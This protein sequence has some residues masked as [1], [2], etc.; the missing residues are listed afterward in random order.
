MATAQQHNTVGPN[1]A[2]IYDLS[3]LKDDPFKDGF[4]TATAAYISNLTNMVSNQV[5]NNLTLSKTEAD[6]LQKNA[7][8]AAKQANEIAAQ[9]D[10]AQGAQDNSNL[11][12]KVLGYLTGALMF[13]GGLISGDFA[14]MAMAVFTIT[15]QAS[16]GQQ[17]LENALPSNQALKGLCELAISFGEGVGFGGLGMALEKSITGIG[18]EAIAKTAETTVIKLGVTRFLSLF[19]QA[20]MMNNTWMDLLSATGMS[21]DAAT[22]LSIVIGLGSAI[23][24]SALAAK[25][26]EGVWLELSKAMLSEQGLQTFQKI[27]FGLKV[28]SNLMQVGKSAAQIAEAEYIKQVADILAKLAVMQKFYTI[29]QAMTQQTQQAISVTQDGQSSF[30]QSF[31]DIAHTYPSL[32]QMWQQPRRV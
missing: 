20:N 3:A 18:L 29:V 14:M 11:L 9:E 10:A 4:L 27:I 21:Q 26:G 16:G 32:G 22:G 17:A 30:N 6:M 5:S 7:D 13:I 2:I 1:G 31:V 28:L 15:M 25:C 23:G 19:A 12:G 8:E 24:A